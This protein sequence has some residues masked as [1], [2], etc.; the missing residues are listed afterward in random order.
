MQRLIPLF[1]HRRDEVLTQYDDSR[2]WLKIF[3][4][5]AF[6]EDDLITLNINAG[7]NNVE[8]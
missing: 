4:P 1:P 3:H 8:R 2:L 5:S 6:W 7:V